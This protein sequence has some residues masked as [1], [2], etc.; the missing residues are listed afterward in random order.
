LNPAKPGEVSS[1]SGAQ[2]APISFA[3]VRLSAAPFV[4]VDGNG[5]FPVHAAVTTHAKTHLVRAM[6]SIWP[7][8]SRVHHGVVSRACR[9]YGSQQKVIGSVGIATPVGATALG[10]QAPPEAVSV[11]LRSPR[12]W[13]GWHENGRSWV[14]GLPVH[15]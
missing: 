5:L 7:L 4:S 14:I 3:S 8:E 13:T 15:V 1:A 12:C 2:L 6:H 11:S 10:V 9:G